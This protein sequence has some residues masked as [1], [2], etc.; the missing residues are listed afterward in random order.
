MKIEKTTLLTM[1]IALLA[2]APVPMTAQSQETAQVPA[3]SVVT[4]IDPTD[5]FTRL[6]VRNEYRSRQSGE[7]INLFLPRLEY[8]LSKTFQALVEIPVAYSDPEAV[9]TDSETGLGDIRLR[10]AIRA[11]RGKGYAVVVATDLVMD[12]ASEATLGLGKYR[13]GPLVFASIEVPRLRST[14]FPFYQ[15]YFSFAGDRNRSDINYASIRPS[16]ILT[17]WPNRWYTVIDPNFFVDFERDTD[18]GMTLEL[19]IGH[20]LGKNMN[21]YIRPGIGVY[22]D[23]PQVYDWNFECGLRYYFR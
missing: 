23:I 18:S 10:G 3:K 7:E 4:R 12:T 17:K 14:F 11:A 19:E 22:G 16:V 1:L 8:A 2:L 21:F 15:H 6:V 9:E 13:L 20:P 5:F